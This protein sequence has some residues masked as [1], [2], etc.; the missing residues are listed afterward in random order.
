MLRADANLDGSLHSIIASSTLSLLSIIV[1][2]VFE[3]TAKRIPAA[4]MFLVILSVAG[5]VLPADI[6]ERWIVS[7]RAQ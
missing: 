2:W 7:L 1:Y 3:R 5:A 6:S 4:P